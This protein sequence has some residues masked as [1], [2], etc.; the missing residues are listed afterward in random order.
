MC[1]FDMLCTREKT[2]TDAYRF[3][4]SLQKEGESNFSYKEKGQILGQTDT[5]YLPWSHSQGIHT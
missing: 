1:A 3:R 2:L 5:P 4:V